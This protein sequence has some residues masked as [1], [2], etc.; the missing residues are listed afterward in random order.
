MTEQHREGR[1]YVVCPECASEVLLDGHEFATDPEWWN[2]LYT[3]DIGQTWLGFMCDWEP[4]LAAF[5]A[6]IFRPEPAAP[7]S[8]PEEPTP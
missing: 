7:T 8:A 1:E 5:D 6:V 2:G 4:C 3:T